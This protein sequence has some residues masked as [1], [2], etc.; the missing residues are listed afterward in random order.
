MTIHD[1]LRFPRRI[2]EVL[3]ELHCAAKAVRNMANNQPIPQREAALKS[4]VARQ[5]EHIRKLESRSDSRIEELTGELSNA[6]DAIKRMEQDAI[7]CS[8]SYNKLNR[9]K[10]VKDARITE[11]ESQIKTE[12]QKSAA[13]S[14]S[15]EALRTRNDTEHRKMGELEAKR[16]ELESQILTALDSLD[17]ANNEITDRKIRI[18]KLEGKNAQLKRNNTEIDASR[19]EWIRKCN[20][21]ES[22]LKAR[23]SQP[24][25]WMPI[26]EFENEIGRVPVFMNERG[27]SWLSQ[28]PIHGATHFLY[29]DGPMPVP[30]KPEPQ[31]VAWAVVDENGDILME[32]G[33]EVLWS[34][35]TTDKAREFCEK[36]CV[37]S[38]YSQR[39]LKVVGLAIVEE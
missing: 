5:L 27:Y 18:D 38:M 23:D 19:S 16:D 37:N 32:N 1:I 6:R 15:C 17:C 13:W 25:P 4:Q 7:M 24:L 36:R 10:E 9:E 34:T 14:E 31:V 26:G 11:L 30:A 33:I 22:Q 8:A 2:S 29:L 20:E 35:A 12:Q 21:L 3:D 39:S 28:D